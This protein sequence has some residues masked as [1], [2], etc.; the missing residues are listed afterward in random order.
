MKKIMLFVGLLSL[1]S[2]QA[3]TKVTKELG[4]FST[5]KVFN[6]IEVELIP[7]QDHKL[8]I[9]GKK[10]EMMK[11]KQVNNTLK[12]TLPFS[13]KPDENAANGEVRV[14]LY[15]NKPI[16]TIDAN[17]GA[18]IT[19]SDIK[20]KDLTVKTQERALINL[21]VDTDHTFVKASSGGV[22]KLTGSSKTQEIDADL[23]GEY[24]GF[25]LQTSQSINA[26]AGSGAK[27]E[28]HISGKLNAKVTF[29]GSIFY[30]GNPE[31]VKDKKVVGG[32]IQKKD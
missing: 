2:I 9:T 28:I 30:K 5:L 8:E 22:V 32:I 26:R 4:E 31:V 24:F 10:S 15:Y 13:L 1:L 19:G 3:Q 20:Q 6:G 12:F 16:Q 7:S 27:V 21:V 23:Y 17:E 14:K 11:I 18:V 25:G 29:G